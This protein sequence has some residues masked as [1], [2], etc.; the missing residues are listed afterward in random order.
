MHGRALSIVASQAFWAEMEKLA[1][2]TWTAQGLHRRLGAYGVP[3][4]TWDSNPDFM[5]WTERLVGKRHLDDMTPTELKRVAIQIARKYKPG[6]PG[7]RKVV[8]FAGQPT[9]ALSKEERGIIL[10]KLKA[11]R[12]QPGAVSLKKT[13]AGYS[14]HTHRARSK[15]YPTVSA[16]PLSKVKFIASTG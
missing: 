8:H 5:D 4:A 13:K 14:V 2:K 9:L 1:E 3:R 7:P 16:I 12:E 6:K 10:Q 15:F 11:V